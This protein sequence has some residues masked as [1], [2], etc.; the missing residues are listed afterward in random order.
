[1]TFNP[2]NKIAQWLMDNLFG[3]NECDLNCGECEYLPE[4]FKEWVD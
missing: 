1:M 4:I 2:I 3:D